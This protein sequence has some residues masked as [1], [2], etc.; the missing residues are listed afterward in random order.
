M[1]SIYV[2]TEIKRGKKNMKKWE[3]FNESELLLLLLLCKLLCS[4]KYIE[5]KKT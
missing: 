1:E 5:F 4:V 3:N 2:Y